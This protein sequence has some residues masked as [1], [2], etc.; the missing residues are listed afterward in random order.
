MTGLERIGA[1]LQGQFADSRAFTMTLSLYGARLS[2]AAPKDY[3][4]GSALYR[5]GQAEV[6]ALVDPD[7]LF[8]PFVMP[9]EA[10]AWGATLAWTERAPPNVGKPLRSTSAFLDREAPRPDSDPRLAYLVESVR[11]V[12]ADNAGIRPVAAVATC[13]SDLPAMALG[14]DAWLEL[15]LFDPELAARVLERSGEHFRALCAAYA[16][17]G[18]AFVAVPVM[19][20]NPRILP[21]ALV[22]ERIVPYLARE[23]GAAGLPVVFHHGANPLAEYL[24]LFAGL[25]GVAG[26]ALAERDD[27]GAARAALGP[28]TLLLGGVEGPTLARRPLARVLEVARSALRNRAADPRFVFATASADVPWDT[29]P[30]TLEALAAAARGAELARGA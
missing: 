11:L 10:E 15:L 16:A 19:F 20:A 21:E 13:P 6:A 12:A 29:E 26:F 2:G 22:R 25:P 7:I 14:I 23:F 8:G 27:S 17:A 4:R 28:G 1:A 9:L 24:P 30:A 18:A 5:R 3:Y